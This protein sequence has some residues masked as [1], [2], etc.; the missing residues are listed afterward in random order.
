MYQVS[1]KVKICRDTL[2]LH[3]L[4]DFTSN[5]LRRRQKMSFISGTQLGC[6]VCSDGC[7]T[8]TER[9]QD[10]MGLQEGVHLYVRAYTY[11]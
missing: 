11:T 8:K 10:N 1:E 3:N 2:T 6:E 4:S 7:E 9:K 5:K